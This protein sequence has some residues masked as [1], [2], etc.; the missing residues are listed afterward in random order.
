MPS[1]DDLVDAS[2]TRCFNDTVYVERIEMFSDTDNDRYLC[3]C[4]KC[5]W[6]FRVTEPEPQAATEWPLDAT[7]RLS[8]G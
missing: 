8:D 4:G 5:G 3:R 2:C 6:R 1:V 7:L